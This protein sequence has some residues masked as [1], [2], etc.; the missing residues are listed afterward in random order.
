[1]TFIVYSPVQHSLL[2]F[3]IFILFKSKSLKSVFDS[4]D[5]S[6]FKLYARTSGFKTFSTTLLQMQHVNICG[7]VKFPQLVTQPSHPFSLSHTSNIKS[8]IWRLHIAQ[9]CKLETS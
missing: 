8:N 5:I 1:M 6:K 2:G 3:A 7:G 9:G 4:S